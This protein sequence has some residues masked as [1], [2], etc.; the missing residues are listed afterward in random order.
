MSRKHSHDRKPLLPIRGERGN[1]GH[2]EIPATGVNFDP[3]VT[4]FH[5]RLGPRAGSD[6]LE[7]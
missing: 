3:T 7:V 1:T 2:W 6:A 5:T 4:V